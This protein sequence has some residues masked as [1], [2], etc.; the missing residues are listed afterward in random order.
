MDTC[1]EL[2]LELESVQ[3][4]ILYHCPILL[5][6]CI[7]PAMTRLP[8][9]YVRAPRASS[10]RVIRVLA[11]AVEQLAEKHLFRREDLEQEG[12]EVGIDQLNAEGYHPFTMTFQSLEIDGANNNV[13]NTVARMSAK[14][15]KKLQTLVYELRKRVEKEGWQTALP[16]DPH[17]DQ[18]SSTTDDM[19]SSTSMTFRPRIR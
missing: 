5:D 14:S 6:A 7:P 16:P 1:H 15:T 9:L 12:E 4:A 19:K 10:S 8:L 2:L 17:V 11:S 18:G 3:R 13:L